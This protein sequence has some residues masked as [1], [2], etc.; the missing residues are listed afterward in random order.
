MALR[1]MS[2]P[3]NISAEPRFWWQNI[4][5]YQWRVLIIT[6]LGWTFDVMD[7][8]I[9]NFIKLPAC[10]EL[11][12]VPPTDP[13]V[14]QWAGG[15]QTALLCGWATGGIIFGVLGDKLGRTRTMVITILVYS[16]FTGLAYFAQNV[17]QLALFRFLTGLGVGGEWA[18]GASL[19]AEVFPRRSR[20]W[21]ACLLQGGASVGIILG[22]QIGYW[23]GDENW[24]WA[25]VVGIVPALLVF[26]VR[27]G[28]KEPQRWQ[29]AAH[30]HAASEIG[31]L[32]EIF[33]P[34]FRRRTIVGVLLGLS[35][36]FGIWGANYWTPELLKTLVSKDQRILIVNLQIVAQLAGFLFCAP[37][38]VYGSRRLA[39]AFYFLGSLISTPLAFH[40]SVDYLS[41]LWLIPIMGFFTGGMFSAYI[42]YFPELYPTRLRATG[43]GFCYNVARYAAAPGPWL[44]GWL[45][46]FLGR[47]HQLAPLAALRWSATFI[48]LI[49]IVG[50][51]ATYFAEETKGKPLP[52]D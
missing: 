41:G 50:L 3:E 30:T 40:F 18:A 26:W 47:Q 52:E 2:E 39:F 9:F 44:M 8:L 5:L 33:S 15:I 10:S 43:A 16:I 31:S 4:T 49:Y 17:W 28:L 34:R 6:F 51:L 12:Q 7:A 48:A 32:R 13:A 11:L 1:F 23:L 14:A 42:I 27:L 35:G 25:F 21:M 36:V 37:L 22:Q 38:A 45:Q 46:G 24:R 19:L 20:T 29:K